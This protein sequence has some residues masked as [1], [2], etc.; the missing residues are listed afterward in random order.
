MVI[1]NRPNITAVQHSDPPTHH[2]KPFT[3]TNIAMLSGIGLWQSTRACRGLA[4]SASG[5]HARASHL[6]P[7]TV[8]SLGSTGSRSLG[9]ALSWRQ[10]PRRS[11][12]ELA[13]IVERTDREPREHAEPD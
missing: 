11:S 9:L 7:R 2:P 6:I 12:P 1:P 13:R 4:S 8:R 10:A 5:Y 3:K